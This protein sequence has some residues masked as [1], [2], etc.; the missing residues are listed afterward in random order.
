MPVARGPQISGR[1]LIVVGVAGV[2]AA[3]FLMAFVI[4]VLGQSDSKVDVRLGDDRFRNI[5]ARSMSARIASSGPVLFPDLSAGGTRDVYVQHLGTDPAQGWLAFDAR[6][7]GAPRD[8][9]LEWR[10]DRRVFVDKCDTSVVVPADGQGQ[11]QYS[12]TVN[13]DGKVVIDLNL[14]PATPAVPVTT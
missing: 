2:L 7:P 1:S 6:R 12:A 4:W 8:C 9:F 5:D 11:R 14:A 10:A 13:S 3:A